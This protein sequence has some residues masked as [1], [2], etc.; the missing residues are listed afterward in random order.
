MKMCLMGRVFLGVGVSPC[1][2]MDCGIEW[3]VASVLCFVSC[4]SLLG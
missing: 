2:E 4:A 1:L 3:L